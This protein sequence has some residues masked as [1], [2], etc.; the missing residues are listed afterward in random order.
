MAGDGVHSDVPCLAAHLPSAFGGFKIVA[1]DGV[2]S[3][4]LVPKAT[5]SMCFL[6]SSPRLMIASSSLHQPRLESEMKHMSAFAEA[7]LNQQNQELMEEI[8][9]CGP[10][11][12]RLRACVHA[13]GR[14]VAC[15]RAAPLKSPFG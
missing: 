7:A 14:M 5:L 6:H 2:H 10:T 4:C 15:V 8:E 1:G 9:V 3:E 11:E 12:K 13:R